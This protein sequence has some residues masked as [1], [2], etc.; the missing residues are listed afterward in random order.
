MAL[1]QP[2]GSIFAHMM[3]M[4]KL[5]IAFFC[6]LSLFCANAQVPVNMPDVPLNRQLLHDNIDNSQKA[7]IRMENKN[8]AVFP[9]SKD[10][11]VNLQITQLLN[12]RVNNMQA[13]VE[14]DST[15]SE[16]DKYTW[17][18]GINDMLQD[19][20][21]VY[22]MKAIKGVLLG[23]L[24]IAYDEAMHA[25]IQ[26][27]SIK[28]IVQK[29]ELEVGTILV[30]N[31]AFQKNSG[32]ASSK[33]VL[34]LKLCQREPKNILKIIG[35]NL[36]VPFADSLIAAIAHR[37]PEEIYNFAAAGDSL[38]KKIM[39]VKEPLVR[40]ISRMA[41]TKSGQF[42]F[43]FLDDIYHGKITMDS[44]SKVKDD[45][46]AYYKLLVHTQIRYAERV[47]RKDTPLVMRALT[48]KLRQKATDEF[49]DNIN[50]LHD[51]KSE[52][53]R[54]KSIENLTPAELYY[55]PV[56]GEDVIYTSSYLGVYKR[57]FERMDIPRSDTLLKWVG[58]D[59][60]KKFIKMAAAYNEL[61]N[62][63]S[64]M[65]QEEAEILMKNFVKGLEKTNTLEDAVDVANSF[66]SID[67]TAI[68]KLILSQVEA[69]L[70]QNKKLG[71]RRGQTIYGLLDNIFLSMD[72]SGKID[73]AAKLGIPP[74]YFMPA[75]S[76]KD[77]SGKIIIQQFFYG[78]KDGIAY[79][80]PFLSAFTN[81]NWKII[82]RE[83][84]VEVR[85]TKGTPVVIYTNRPF[86]TEKDLDQKAQEALGDYLDSLNEEPTVVIHRGH[87]YHVNSTISQLTP[88]AK[89]VVLGDCGGY[90]SLNNV[91]NIC[92]DAHIIA[93]KQVG[94]GVINIALIEA[95][96]ETLRKGQ[97]LNWPLMWKNLESKF[98][99]ASD[100]DKFDD[101]VPPYK[102]L[103]AIFIKA[104]KSEMN[105][106]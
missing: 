105:E 5:Y 21:N 48:Q 70:Q 102:N 8:A 61:D 89:V 85:S 86:D 34:V 12:V 58:N 56:L 28:P 75:Q 52:A 13:L 63:L 20:I 78:D 84:W 71:N 26:H 16:S 96:T 100:K 80:N 106:R 44:I 51:E 77:S 38:A 101:Y 3:R 81:S 72:S 11:D 40:S 33:D 92:P 29:N 22:R 69:S 50:A 95:I 42:Y 60:Y 45:G 9:A 18:R 32:L 97:D 15:I 35:K 88:T 41:S 79:F 68:R 14:S 17:L 4:K 64:R 7:I 2:I 103:G 31:F 93:S 94:A 62:F 55:L 30:R 67:N 104:Y 54:F 25:Q 98:K 82:R 39:S 1:R 91:L 59:F 76:L 87:S 6:S 23:D 47:A 49:I 46:L 27:R 65:N 74:V 66:A 19:F 57:I 83:Q 37:N 90:Q 24:V 36:D 10:I 53:V 73:V 43:P 99:A